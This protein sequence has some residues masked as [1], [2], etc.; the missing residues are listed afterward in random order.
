MAKI[1]FPPHAVAKLV[2]IFA[3]AV[4]ILRFAPIRGI[5][6]IKKRV[7]K[8]IYKMNDRFY[9]SICT[10]AVLIFLFS[11]NGS[12]SYF[13][14]SFYPVNFLLLSNFS[15]VYTVL[16]WLASPA[17]PAARSAASGPAPVSAPGR[18]RPRLSLMASSLRDVASS[19]A[20]LATR[21]RVAALIG[22]QLAGQPERRRHRLGRRRRRGLRRFGRQ[23][24]GI[25]L[26]GI[27]DSS[28]ARLLA[29]SAVSP[30]MTYAIIFLAATLVAFEVRCT[31][32][33][34]QMLVPSTVVSYRR[35][36]SEVFAPF[37]REMFM[38]LRFRRSLREIF[39]FAK[40]VTK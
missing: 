23:G 15:S 4:R 22:R 30:P 17:A 10:L 27:T 1:V 36:W 34:A 40:I 33:P 28:L 3:E 24:G 16:S 29:G 6:F 14:K 13:F 38:I 8:N 25:D 9:G 2:D 18:G 12:L 37:N 5:Y 21:L 39:V 20:Q 35:L 11:K 19:P 32:S 26:T 7:T 31:P